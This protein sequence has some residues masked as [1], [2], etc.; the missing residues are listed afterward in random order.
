MSVDGGPSRCPTAGST[1]QCAERFGMWRLWD[2]SAFPTVTPVLAR[3]I[4]ESAEGMSRIAGDDDPLMPPSP[5]DLISLLSFVPND[6]GVPED[7]ASFGTQSAYVANAPFIGLQVL[8]PSQMDTGL[9]VD[10]QVQGLFRGTNQAGASVPIR[11]VSTLTDAVNGDK[12]TVLTIQELEQSQHRLVLLTP[13]LTQLDT[14]MLGARANRLKGLKGWLTRLDPQADA[15]VERDLAVVTTS[16]GVQV[17]AVNPPGDAPPGGGAPA[18]A[19]FDTTGANLAPGLSPGIGRITT[20]GGNPKVAGS[21]PTGVA[22]D[23]Q[24]QLLFVA[25]GTAGLTIIDLSVP[26]GSRDDDGDGIDDRVLGT[27]DLQG[28][29]AERVTVWRGANG[30]LIAAVATG[31]GGISLIQLEPENLPDFELATAEW[32]LA[33]LFAPRSALAAQQGAVRAGCQILIEQN[34]LYADGQDTTNVTAKVTPEAAGVSFGFSVDPSG[35]GTISPTSSTTGID[36][37]AG[38]VFT[39]ASAR[40]AARLV[41]TGNGTKLRGNI[42]SYPGYNVHQ[43]TVTDADFVNAN[44]MSEQDV[45]DFLVSKGSALAQPLPNTNELAATIIHNAATNYGINPKVILVTIQKESSLI[46]RP[47]LDLDRLQKAMGYNVKVRANLGFANQV[48]Y[49]TASLSAHF[50]AFRQLPPLPTAPPKARVLDPFLFVSA[51]GG[52]YIM[53]NRKYTCLDLTVQFFINSSAT[54][55]EMMYTPWVSNDGLDGSRCIAPPNTPP[56]PNCKKYYC[57]PDAAVNRDGLG[58][59]VYLFEKIWKEFFP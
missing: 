50:Q 33:S 3:L 11:S 41:A 5:Y 43:L 34:I 27:V 32:P 58:G 39:A 35:A 48:N 13:G 51:D 12:D 22:Y 16:G 17:L 44:A 1:R 4:N 14:F 2:L 52:H 59:G 55:A 53:T 26:G 46:K 57:R 49:G 30:V 15:T 47:D 21:G 28:A 56:G 45:Q 36:G 31:A 42:Y 29:R 38:S 6:I 54:Y 23:P 19:S 9:L 18:P 7:L 25:D 10:D 40:S 37:L 20:P 8:I 24:T